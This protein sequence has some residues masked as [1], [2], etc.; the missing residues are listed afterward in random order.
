MEHS[1]NST[2]ECHWPCTFGF[3]YHSCIVNVSPNDN[4]EGIE[5][6]RQEGNHAQKLFLANFRARLMAMGAMPMGAMY[7]QYVT[8]R[9]QK[10]LDWKKVS[11]AQELLLANF[12]ARLMGASQ[13]MLL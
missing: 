10:R 6:A 5:R 4:A 7:C 8:P 13:A 11:H 9:A 2:L 1:S 3:I 12:R